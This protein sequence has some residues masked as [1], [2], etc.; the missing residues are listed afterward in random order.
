MISPNCEENGPFL[1]QIL[2]QSSKANSKTETEVIRGKQ[3]KGTVVNKL[4]TVD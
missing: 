3:S 1:L 2:L 4:E